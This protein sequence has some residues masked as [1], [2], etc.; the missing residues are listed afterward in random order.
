L[1]EDLPAAEQTPLADL[2]AF[3]LEAYLDAHP[4]AAEDDGE[5]LIFDQFE[6]NLTADPSDGAGRLAI[7]AELGAALRNRNR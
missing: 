3:S 1:E 5:V 6:E 4:P 2:A 7:F